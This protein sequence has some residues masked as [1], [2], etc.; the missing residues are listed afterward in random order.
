[1][2]DISVGDYVRTK[3]GLIGKVNYIELTGKGTRYAGELISDTIIQFNDSRI[4]ERRVSEKYIVKHSK[5]IID[6]IE[7][8]DFVNG[9]IVADKYLYAGEKPVLETVGIKYNAYCLS[10]G[11]IREILTKEQYIQNCYTVER[12]KKC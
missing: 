2:K 6:L 5:N 7:V 11:D 8:G 9:N 10:E 1:M 12:T 4:Y 3:S